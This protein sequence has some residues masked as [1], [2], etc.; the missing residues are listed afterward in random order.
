MRRL[1]LAGVLVAGGL[2]S[3]APASACTVDTCWFTEPVCSRVTFC[4]VCYYGPQGA[5]YCLLP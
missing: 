5:R 2:L 4:H 3:A 1:L